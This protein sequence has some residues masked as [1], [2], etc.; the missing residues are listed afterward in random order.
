[1]LV[2]IS[3]TGRVQ[4][5]RVVRWF[6]SYNGYID[7]LILWLLIQMWARLPSRSGEMDISLEDG[8]V[9]LDKRKSISRLLA[10][11]YNLD[12]SEKYLA[13][14]YDDIVGQMKF[15]VRRIQKKRG[16]AIYF[17]SSS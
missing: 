5:F 4:W 15:V 7:L 17:R 8:A 13:I 2:H 3:P 9:Y 16:I 1:M 11:H 14:R 10:Q 6:F 12:T